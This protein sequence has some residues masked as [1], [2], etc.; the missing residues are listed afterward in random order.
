MWETW[1]QSLGQ[2]DP[3]EKA[4]DTHSSMSSMDRGAWWATVHG[5]TNSQTQLSDTSPS[6]KKEGQIRLVR[7]RSLLQPVD[8]NAQGI[9]TPSETCLSPGLVIRVVSFHLLPSPLPSGACRTRRR[10]AGGENQLEES[11]ARGDPEG[12]VAGMRSSR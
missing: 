5:V 10:G 12:Q 6:S 2:D 11:G 8:S 9:L 3:L 4:M 7:V 1:V